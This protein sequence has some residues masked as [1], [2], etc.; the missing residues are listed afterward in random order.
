MILFWV[1]SIFLSCLLLDKISY[2][3]AIFFLFLEYILAVWNVISVSKWRWYFSVHIPHILIF[4][5]DSTDETISYDI[6][7]NE[8]G[9]H[10]RYGNA[11]WLEHD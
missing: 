3:L 10:R 4:L 1:V 8:Y 5:Y 7:D 9:V 11:R 6:Y 2:M